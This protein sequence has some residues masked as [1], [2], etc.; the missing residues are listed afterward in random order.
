MAIY[1][2]PARNEHGGWTDMISVRLM[3]T[4]FD[5]YGSLSGVSVIAQPLH[6]QRPMG[7]LG[8]YDFGDFHVG[9]TI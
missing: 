5:M 2:T 3:C 7:F 6:Y 4:I 9:L 8:S 1:I